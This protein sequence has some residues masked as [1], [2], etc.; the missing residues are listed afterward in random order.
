V[1]EKMTSREAI[2]SKNNKLNT[3]AY[4]LV[5]YVCLLCVFLFVCNENISETRKI[6]QKED[7]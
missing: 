4:M 6:I 1:S 2:T 3:L 5:L 7:S